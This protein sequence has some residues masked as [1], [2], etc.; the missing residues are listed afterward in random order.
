MAALE[1]L[2]CQSVEDCVADTDATVTEEV[3]GVAPSGVFQ[4]QNASNVTSAPISST[5][6]AADAQAALEPIFPG[7]IQVARVDEP[8]ITVW[9]VTYLAFE[10][11]RALPGTL[12][13][14]L[15]GGTVATTRIQQGTAS[16][17]GSFTMAM[18]G[19]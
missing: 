7:G 19:R 5:A 17:Q 11:T 2:K 13:D 14:S 10:G 8:A 12:Q 3:Q 4:L 9:V 18:D 6:S 1:V 16:A 15:I